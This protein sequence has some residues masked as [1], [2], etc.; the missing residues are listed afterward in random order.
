MV[1]FIM[2]MHQ[3]VLPLSQLSI[4]IGLVINKI[5]GIIIKIERF[6]VIHLWELP[7]ALTVD[8]NNRHLES[9]PQELCRPTFDWANHDEDSGN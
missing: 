7:L 6:R 3:N 1:Y 5:I 4:V 8:N 9:R 2:Q